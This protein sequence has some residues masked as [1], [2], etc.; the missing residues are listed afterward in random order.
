MTMVE[1]QGGDLTVF[2][3][4]AEFHKPGATR[5]MVANRSGY[6]AA[7][8]TTMLGWAVQRLGAGREKAGAPVDPHAGIAFHAR[9]GAYV[10]KGQKLATLYATK[11]EML[12]EPEALIDG[13]LR[14]SE[15]KPEAVALVGRVFTR[16]EAERH[17]G[18]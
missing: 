3:N 11:Q 6:I 12:A 4:M 17:L 8:D 18:G 7:M 1:A 5:V 15:E 14:F 16:V 13:A 2:E 9:R 10:E